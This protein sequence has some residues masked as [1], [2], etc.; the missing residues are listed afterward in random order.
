MLVVC[1]RISVAGKR[2]STR[3]GF[4]R[5]LNWRALCLINGKYFAVQTLLFG[6]NGEINEMKRKGSLYG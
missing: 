6:W 5:L 3:K 4:W 2:L 1:C